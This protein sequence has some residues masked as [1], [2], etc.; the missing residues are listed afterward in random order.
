MSRENPKKRTL[1]SRHADRRH[2]LAPPR[3]IRVH[4]Q[5]GA[6]AGS[7]FEPGGWET[8]TRI[9]AASL[10]T[11]ACAAACSGPAAMDDLSS[12]DG[13]RHCP[14]CVKDGG[15]ADSGAVDG[16]SLDAGSVDSGAKDVVTND[17]GTSVDSGTSADTGV[18]SASTL[19]QRYPGDMG[20]WNDPSVV[21]DEHFNEGSVAAVS[22]RYETSDNVSGM[23]IVNDAPASA[24]L[25]VSMQFTANP[26]V[27]NN[28]PDLYKNF[29]RFSPGFEELYYRWYV[30]YE[31]NIP[32]HHAGLWVGGYNPP[33]DW[34]APHAGTKPTGSDRFSIGVEP[35]WGVGTSSP[36]FDFYNYWM[37]M[38]TCSS[39]NGAYWGNDLVEQ[40]SFTTDD[41]NWVCLEMHLKVNTDIASAAGSVMEI[42]KNDNLVQAFTATGPAGGWLQDHY[43]PIGATGPQCT[44]YTYPMNGPADLQVRTTTALNLN[45]FWVQSYVTSGGAASMW[46]SNMVVAKTRIGC[47]AP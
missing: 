5:G 18:T 24:S 6:M 9:V 31:P 22:A 47:I 41:N 8:F 44:Q 12:E 14:R 4:K 27:G 46:Y 21:W 32:W 2:A 3:V 13:L 29:A 15:I 25:R 1:G 45:Y 11:C 17:S 28:G 30:K 7:A 36:Q 34:A 19:S 20:I 23:A 35:V 39:C 38:H 10:S 42:W 16:A 26:S 33:Q 37:N 40:T 43:C